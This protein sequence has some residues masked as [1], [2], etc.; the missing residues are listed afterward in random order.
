[1]NGVQ[2][3]GSSNLL[4]QTTKKPVVIGKTTGFHFV[5]KIGK[6][7]GNRQKSSCTVTL[8]LHFTVTLYCYENAEQTVKLVAN[9]KKIGSRP[10]AFFEHLL[11]G[12]CFLRFL[13][14][15]LVEVIVHRKHTSG[16]FALVLAVVLD[17]LD[18]LF[19]QGF[20]VPHLFEGDFVERVG[21]TIA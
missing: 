7:V 8:L 13:N 1:M 5:L 21:K 15:P 3:A 4:T 9:L 17:E 6:I 14:L 18:N 2:E 10:S 12:L 20:L 11:I 19:V 16:R